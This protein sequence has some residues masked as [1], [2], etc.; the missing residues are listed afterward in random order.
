MLNTNVLESEIHTLGQVPVRLTWWNG[1]LV[2]VE[3]WRT[4]AHDQV[5]Y[6]VIKGDRRS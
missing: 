2:G 1:K 4:G 3:Y 6:T 5:G